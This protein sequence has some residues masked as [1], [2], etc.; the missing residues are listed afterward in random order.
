[1]AWKVICNQERN[2]KMDKTEHSKNSNSQNLLN[3]KQR[4]E[5]NQQY[6]ICS[7]LFIIHL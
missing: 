6:I 4:R 7:S 3:L 5:C 1:M 2:Q